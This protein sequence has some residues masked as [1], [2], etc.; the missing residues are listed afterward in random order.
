MEKDLKPRNLSIATLESST[1]EKKTG[2]KNKL[3][4]T[5][6]TSS[7]DNSVNR[8]AGEIESR[9]DNVTAGTSYKQFKNRLGSFQYNRQGAL[10][11]L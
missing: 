10:K 1:R 2:S 7:I 9:H 6:T 4:I 5:I 3:K 8:P 11:L